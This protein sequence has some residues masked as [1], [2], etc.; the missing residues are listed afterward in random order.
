[1]RVARLDEQVGSLRELVGERGPVVAAGS[2]RTDA[3]LAADRE[4]RRR[5]LRTRLGVR[6]QQVAVLWA[7][8]CRDDVTGECLS[9]SGGPGPDP[10]RVAHELGPEHVLL[11]V[12]PRCGRHA[13]AGPGAGLVDVSAHHP[14]LA[15][16]LAG[17]VLACD[18]AVLDWSPLRFDL[19][20]A[21]RPVVLWVPDLDDHLDTEGL[22]FDLGRSSAGPLVRT[23]DEVLRAVA[24]HEGLR[25]AWEERRRELVG[26]FDRLDDGAATGRVVEALL[27]DDPVR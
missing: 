13:A 14:D 23:T 15:L 4:A 18:V 3:L 22:A 20:V 21:G 9:A 19:A 2:P 11:Q 6:E 5:E 1:M 8:T 10:A 27:A 25:S 12:G 7:T 16:D 26:F 17:L 24:D